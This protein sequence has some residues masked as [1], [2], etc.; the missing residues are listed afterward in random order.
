[1]NGAARQAC[2]YAA[3]RR[4]DSKDVTPE[5]DAPAFAADGNRSTQTRGVPLIEVD[6]PL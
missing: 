4:I 3:D 6:A 2:R 5:R 1:M